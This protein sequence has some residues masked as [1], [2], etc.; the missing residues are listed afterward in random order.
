[1]T[2]I[3]SFRRVF[4]LERRIYAVDGLRLNPSGIP[5][6]GVVYL[7]VLVG[8]ANLSAPVPVVGAALSVV[9]WYVRDVALPATLA[10]ALS[11]VRIDGRTFHQ[12]AR[13]QIALVSGPRRVTGLCRPSTAGARWRPPNILVLPDGSDARLRALRYSGPGAVRVGVPVRTRPAIRRVRGATLVLGPDPAETR[14]G[15]GVIWVARG[16]RIRFTPSAGR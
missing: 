7:L 13:A 14:P 12:A 4:D 6:R 11:I 15:V 10:A 3:R 2:E 9:P 5:V 1:M 8:L 16:G